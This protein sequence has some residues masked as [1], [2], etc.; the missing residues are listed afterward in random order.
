VTPPRRISAADTFVMKF[1]LPAA[2]VIFSVGLLVVMRRHWARSDHGALDILQ[3]AGNATLFIVAVQAVR[4]L[5]G[6]KR[7]ALSGESLHV[8]NFLREIVVRLADVDSV[9]E[10]DIKGGYRV[11]VN[12]AHDT[13]FRRRIVFSP[14]GWSHPRP[15]Q[16]VAELRAAVDAA[17]HN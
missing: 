12:L 8:S 6:L 16:I 13:P 14:I 1:A 15:H 4:R 2:Y 5:R 10:V 9:D 3:L 7:V 17:K 11:V